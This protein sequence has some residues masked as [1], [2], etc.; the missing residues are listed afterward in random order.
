MR[1]LEQQ[2]MGSRRESS[3]AAARGAGRRQLQQQLPE[4]AK[5]RNVAW[6]TRAELFEP[7]L[8][9]GGQVGQCDCWGLCGLCGLW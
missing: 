1:L 7:L 5:S 9:K 3:R 2:Q 6:V 8:V 4:A